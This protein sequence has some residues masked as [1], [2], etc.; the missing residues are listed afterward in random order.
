MCKH[1]HTGAVNNSHKVRLV[2]VTCF[3]QAQ[4][5][6]FYNQAIAFSKTLSV[7]LDITES[8]PGQSL[9]CKNVFTFSETL[10]LVR[11]E[12]TTKL[13]VSCKKLWWIIIPLLSTHVWMSQKHC[14]STSA[15][16]V[17]KPAV[18][19]LCLMCKLLL[20]HV[21]KFYCVCLSSCKENENVWNQSWYRAWGRSGGGKVRVPNNHSNKGTLS[22]P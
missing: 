1:H 9:A 19:G 10:R 20:Y 15:R 8:L 22:Y 2:S 13:P 3:M 16:T 12:M 5:I 4:I 14:P 17:Q 11:Q 21:S 6:K 18:S 7:S